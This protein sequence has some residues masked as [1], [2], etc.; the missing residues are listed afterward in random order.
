MKFGDIQDAGRRL[1]SAHV[2]LCATDSAGEFPLRD[3]SSRP[4]IDESH[5]EVWEHAGA[6]T[7]A[8]PPPHRAMGAR[9]NSENIFLSLCHTVEYCIG[10][11]FT[12]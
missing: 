10:A 9:N 7:Y 6:V 1:D 12:I 4:V 2:A 8:S 3:T 5:P 11:T